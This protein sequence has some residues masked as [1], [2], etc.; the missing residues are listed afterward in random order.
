MPV[1]YRTLEQI[2]YNIFFCGRQHFVVIF[3]FSTISIPN[4]IRIQIQ[5]GKNDPQKEKKRKFHV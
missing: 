5:E 2:Y 3:D 1:N 4:W